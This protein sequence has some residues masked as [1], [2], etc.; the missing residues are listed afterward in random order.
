MTNGT[1]RGP[2]FPEWDTSDPSQSLAQAYQWAVQ[3]AQSQIDWYANRRQP[4]KHGS[5]WLR[6]LAIILAGIGALCP[7]LDAAIPDNAGVLLSQ[8]AQWGYVSIALAAALVGYDKFFGLSSGWMRYMVTELSLQRTLR[9]FQY[10]WSILTAQKAQQSPPQNNAATLIQRLKD[11]TLQVETLV[12]QET[13]AW[14]T[15]FQANISELEKMLQA[16]AQA[17]APGS[18]KVTVTNA[19][20]FDKVTILLN[21]GQAK[22][23]TGV[24]EGVLDSVPRGPQEVTAVGQKK[25]TQD[26]K[27]SKVV[28]VQPTTMVSVELTIP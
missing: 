10:D 2:K 1:A 18:I 9:E 25:G 20:D 5:Q 4:K 8:L 11:F 26:R 3:N 28:E 23:L 22:E 6:T 16:E 27:D 19:R 14:V 12:R 7:L 24:T 15:E 21:S 17:R 13:D